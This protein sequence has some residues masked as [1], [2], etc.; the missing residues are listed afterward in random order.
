MKLI[1][2]IITVFLGAVLIL[3]FYYIFIQNAYIPKRTL[4]V[5]IFYI[6]V[7][8]LR[9]PML[10]IC[11]VIGSIAYI[12]LDVFILVIYSDIVFTDFL[13]SLSFIGLGDVYATLQILLVASILILLLLSSNR[14]LYRIGGNP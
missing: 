3:S 1:N 9:K 4:L 13:Y 10:W 8:Q 7:L 6:I 14:K 12:I 5:T 2:N 11:G